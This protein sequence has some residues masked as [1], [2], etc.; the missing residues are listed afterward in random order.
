MIAHALNIHSGTAEPMTRR[1]ATA[2]P[3]LYINI[4]RHASRYPGFPV[5]LN[6]LTF[7]RQGM[8]EVYS[9]HRYDITISKAT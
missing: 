5:K 8:Y 3:K 4:N 2:A 9:E 7:L 1:L 6:K